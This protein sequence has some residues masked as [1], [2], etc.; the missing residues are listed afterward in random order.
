M[1]WT[2]LVYL[3]AIAASNAVLDCIRGLYKIVS[4]SG[5][6]THHFELANRVYHSL[7]YF[8]L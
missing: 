4:F 3:V 6:V 7:Y 1:A 5:S 8:V 2:C